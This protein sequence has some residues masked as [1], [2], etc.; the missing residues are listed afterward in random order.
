[1]K[2]LSHDELLDAAEGHGGG[3]EHV[4]ACTACRAEVEA[5]AAALREAKSVDVPEP[6]PLF[7]EHL[8]AR[9]R[10]GCEAGAGTARSTDLEVGGYRTRAWL[11]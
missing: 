3:R 8:A 1:M 10:E 11:R 4:D 7:W 5:L 9:V 6:S 2:H